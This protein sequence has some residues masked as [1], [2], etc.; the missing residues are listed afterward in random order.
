[1]THQIH[2]LQHCEKII[3]L[4]NGLIKITGSYDELVSSG[5][6]IESY[7]PSTSSS[8]QN[9]NETTNLKKST[10]TLRNSGMLMEN[11]VKLIE[12]NENKDIDLHTNEESK[13]D[14][15][16][17]LE[18]NLKFTD[19]SIKSDKKSTIESKKVSNTSIVHKIDNRSSNL[20]TKEEKS[21]GQVTWKVYSYYIHAGG[22]YLFYLIIFFLSSAQG[23]QI[24]S[25]FWL[26]HW[27][28]VSLRAILSNNPL[29]QSD[30]IY[31][32]NYYA[33]FCS[34][35]IISVIFRSFLLAEFRLG[36][37]AVLHDNLL[38]KVLGGTISFYDITPLGR[39]LNRF[40][41]DMLT[42]DEELQQTTN[43][44]TN[45]VSGCIGGLIAVSIA[46][47]GTFLI[48]MIPLIF[49]Y[50]YIQNY[51]RKTNTEIARMESISRSPIY[52]DFSQALTGLTSIRAYNEQSKFIT[53]L[54]NM[55]NYN[56]IAN[57]F[58]QNSSQWLA[59]RL[60]LLGAIITIFI[61]I[62]AVCL[63]NFIPAGEIAL[64]LSYSFLITTQLKL[65]VRFFAQFEG[66][67]NS[68]VSY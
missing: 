17:I 49:I 47:K 20:V 13:A 65:A 42:I 44:L 21:E 24:G 57:I 8:T 59:I 22:V 2:L 1:M 45:Y 5:I 52:A 35:Y 68:V 6:D 31:Y 61:A 32:I 36:T 11:N 63:P 50:N 16:T 58:S 7:I 4:E 46:T 51:F 38:L 56:T 34:L 48:L 53:H 28:T 18:N 10:E 33:I 12:S 9:S 26:S 64:S 40:S 60:D 29:S 27:G 55:V 25:S 3:I 66:Q 37:S 23:F 14:N 30:N 15:T 41:S 62:I 19:K 43:Q 67:M 39:I 54:Q